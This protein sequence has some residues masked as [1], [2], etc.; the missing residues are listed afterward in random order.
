MKRVAEG[1]PA[2]PFVERRPWRDGAFDR[3]L[4]GFGDL[5]EG[6]RPFESK[7]QLAQGLQTV[8]QA[9]DHATSKESLVHEVFK[10]R[11][12]WWVRIGRPYQPGFAYPL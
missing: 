3:P 9:P 10:L 11:Q 1:G 6:V 2:Q 7:R 12:W 8:P 5:I 4:D